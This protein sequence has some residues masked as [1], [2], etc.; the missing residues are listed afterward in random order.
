[1][2][3]SDPCMS[4]LAT[5]LGYSAGE[6][7]ILKLISLRRLVSWINHLPPACWSTFWKSIF[8][9]Q[10][11][12]RLDIMDGISSFFLYFGIC[13]YICLD[14]SYHFLALSLLLKYSLFLSST[15]VLT[16]SID[17]V[18]VLSIKE[19][20][21]ARDT[22]F[23]YQPDIIYS[24]IQIVASTNAAYF[25]VMWQTQKQPPPQEI[26][27]HLPYSDYELITM[28]SRCWWRSNEW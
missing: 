19:S 1:M 4:H 12:C 15:P 28:L 3:P 2:V 21:F 9:H 14:T 20:L 11:G 25:M 13:N 27:R 24:I 23:L 18:S 7:Q 26:S 16:S 22:R 6:F 5:Q 10:L 17:G 8:K